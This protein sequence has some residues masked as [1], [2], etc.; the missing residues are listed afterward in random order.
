ME[1]LTRRESLKRGLTATALIA[2]AQKADTPNSLAKIGIA[3]PTI[4]RP[5]AA[6]FATVQ[7]LPRRHRRH[8]P[9]ACGSSRSPPA[10]VAGRPRTHLARA[11]QR[12]ARGTGNLGILPA[13]LDRVVVDPG[14]D[15]KALC[16]SQKRAQGKR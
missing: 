12:V 8:G 5:P 14:H 6:L 16:G 13:R 2:L 15:P 1:K 11:R 7:R 4:Q 3:G 9:R 10:N